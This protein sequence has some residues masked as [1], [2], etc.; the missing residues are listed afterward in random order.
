MPTNAQIL[1]STLSLTIHWHYYINLL[2]IILRESYTKHANVKHI[3]IIKLINP[4]DAE[5][6]PICHLLALLGAHHI[7]H[8]SRIRIKHLLIKNCGY[9][10]FLIRCAEFLRNKVFIH[11]TIHLCFIYMLSWC[12]IPEDELKT[13]KHVVVL[14]G[15]IC[16]CIF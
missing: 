1:N 13:S 3:W 14:V 8:V 16:K 11:F 10:K 2:H 12:N 5:L 9:H 7:L 6:N 15:C 4:S